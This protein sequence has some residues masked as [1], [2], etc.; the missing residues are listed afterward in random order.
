MA[1]TLLALE[2]TTVLGVVRIAS[3]WS[4]PPSA[5]LARAGVTT[6]SA[7]TESAQRA[8]VRRAMPAALSAL[9]IT[10][11]LGHA[12]HRVIAESG[13]GCPQSAN[14]AAIAPVPVENAA[15]WTRLARIEHTATR[16][17]CTVVTRATAK[18]RAR[19]DS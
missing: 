5:A 13:R 8:L 6:W 10:R 4:S 17:V 18:A 9:R 15:V 1:I 11:D 12:A 19:S 2:A 3:W 16:V 14:L 7:L